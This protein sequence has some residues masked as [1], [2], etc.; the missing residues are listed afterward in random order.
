M[1]ETLFY[2]F[3]KSKQSFYIGKYGTIFGRNIPKPKIIIS[4]DSDGFAKF[5][6]ENQQKSLYLDFLK[7]K[8][9]YGFQLQVLKDD[10]IPAPYYGKINIELNNINRISIF[11]Q[12]LL[13]FWN[14]LKHTTNKT[15][16]LVF[17]TSI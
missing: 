7:E 10:S 3:T 11:G 17:F 12:N 6:G 5:S 14:E 13:L 4:L 1:D 2:D 15:I 16:L 9:P 8:Y